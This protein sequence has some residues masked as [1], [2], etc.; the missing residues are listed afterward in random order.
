MPGIEA[1]AQSADRRAGLADLRELRDD[2]RALRIAPLGVERMCIRA[3]VDFADARAYPRRGL[4]LT[5]LGIDEHAADDAGLGQSRDRG[6]EPR[7]L[8]SDIEPPLGRDLL[9]TLRHQHRHLGLERAGERDHFIGRGH[10]EV[11]L[12]LHQRAQPANVLVLDVPAVFAQVHCN[13][14]GAAQVRFGRRPD[15]VRLVGPTRLSQRRDVVD[16]DAELDH[17][18]RSSLPP[19]PSSSA[20]RSRTTRRLK[21]AR[22]SR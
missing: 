1:H 3:G 22:C 7:L 12:D 17:D 10:L 5:D 6:L 20:C 13:A 19:L 14:V 18:R 4:D 11:K 16:V 21:I 8:R 2:R 15:R 9:A